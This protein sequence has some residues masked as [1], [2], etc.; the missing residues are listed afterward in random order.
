MLSYSRQPVKI[1]V[2]FFEDSVAEIFV[3]QNVHTTKIMK[4]LFFLR[5]DHTTFPACFNFNSKLPLFAKKLNFQKFKDKL[6]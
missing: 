3:Q 1:K 2:S 4:T 6:N 5:N